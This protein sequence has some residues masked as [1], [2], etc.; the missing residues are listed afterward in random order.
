MVAGL[1]IDMDS[2]QGSDLDIDAGM[3]DCSDNDRGSQSEGSGMQ[4]ND[5]VDIDFGCE[6]MEVLTEA[7]N[8]SAEQLD[9]LA[10]AGIR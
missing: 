8:D 9:P 7:G 2:I 10:Q 4:F 5:E 6:P 3:P 1:D